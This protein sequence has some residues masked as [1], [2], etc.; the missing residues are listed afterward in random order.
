MWE[1]PSQRWW[2]GELGGH[3][4]PGETG[5]TSNTPDPEAAS[6]EEGV[7]YGREIVSGLD[8]GRGCRTFRP[9]QRGEVLLAENQDRILGWGG[10]FSTKVS[11]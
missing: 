10:E 3:F 1:M 4:G 8:R 2:S 6:T 11:S 9:G 7:A 5:P